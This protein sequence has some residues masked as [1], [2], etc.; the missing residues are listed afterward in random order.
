[1]R[2]R[3]VVIV[4]TVVTALI[5][6]FFLAPVVSSSVPVGSYGGPAVIS[7]MGYVSPS[8]ALFG[9]GASQASPWYTYQIGC[10]G[11]HDYGPNAN[12]TR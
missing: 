3:N 11:L 9:I 2:P 8:C 6:I 10:S 4:G 12:S 1:M 5:L 7:V